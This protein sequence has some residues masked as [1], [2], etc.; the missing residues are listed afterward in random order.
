[1][2]FDGSGAAIPPI[3]S[4]ARILVAHDLHGGLNP[5]RALISDLVLT[6]SDEVAAAARALDRPVV[7]FDLSL[8]PVEPLG[9]RSAAVFTTGP[10]TLDHLDGVVFASRNLAD[11]AGLARDLERADAEVFVVE[12]KAAAIDVVAE[13][14]AE[15]GI[16]VVFAV[17]EVVAGGLDEELLRLAEVAAGTEAREN[18][19]G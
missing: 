8:R 9:G 16:D 10:A 15:R 7:R 18:V 2:V 4:G 11:R 5:Y 12:L 14:A 17:N 13:H 1:V 6:M 19:V 3:A